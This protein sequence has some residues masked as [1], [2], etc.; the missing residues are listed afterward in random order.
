MNGSDSYAGKGFHSSA[1]SAI[2]LNINRGSYG[3]YGLLT[4]STAPIT[5]FGSAGYTANASV[6]ACK[7]VFANTGSITSSCSGM[8]GL[9]NAGIDRAL[10]VTA[11]KY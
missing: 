4:G 1:Y 10:A 11:T 9:G 3:Q 2:S 7:L 5:N 6:N 8:T